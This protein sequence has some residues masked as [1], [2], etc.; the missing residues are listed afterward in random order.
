[1]LLCKSHNLPLTRANWG[2]MMLVSYSVSNLHYCFLFV[3][4]FFNSNSFLHYTHTCNHGDLS[5]N[6]V[7]IIILHLGIGKLFPFV[8]LFYKKHTL[9]SLGLIKLGYHGY[10]NK[11]YNYYNEP[12]CTPYHLHWSLSNLTNEVKSL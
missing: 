12:N 6:C 8:F 10:D 11:W 3:S 4:N 9:L 1:M 7:S 5:L 2:K